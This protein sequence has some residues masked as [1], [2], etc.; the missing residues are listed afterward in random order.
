MIVFQLL[1]VT[2]RGARLSVSDGRITVRKDDSA[3]PSFLSFDDLDAVVIEENAVSMTGGLLAQLAGKRI[4]LILCGSNHFPAALLNPVFADG[5]D[6][7]RMLQWQI[8]A[9]LPWKKQLWRKLIQAKI[10]GQSANLVQ[11]GNRSMTHLI[12]LVRSGDPDNIESRAAAFYWSH[13]RLFRARKRH[14]QDANQF[15][16]YAYTLLFSAFARYLCAASLNPDIGIHHHGKYNHF[17]LA[18]DLMEPFRPIL[19]H[20][21]F[22]VIDSAPKESELIPET[23]IAL[24]R[25]FYD[26]H[27]QISGKRLSLPDAVNET[28]HSFKRSLQQKDS[29]LFTLPEV[30]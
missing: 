25:H 26:C 19:D 2:E 5:A 11:R 30:L 8:H 28:V 17:S 21:I 29:S 1:C 3:K 12:P 7:H 22:P 4:P 27:V 20:S 18:S 9:P 15:F 24:I 13:L 16:N 23:R 10:A 6:S 14:A